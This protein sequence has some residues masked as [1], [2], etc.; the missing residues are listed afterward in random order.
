MWIFTEKHA[1]LVLSYTGED[2]AIQGML[3]G[4]CGFAIRCKSTTLVGAFREKAFHGVPYPRAGHTPRVTA[5]L[6][7]VC[8]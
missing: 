7:A 6:Q 5:L 3:A 8:T 2:R 4:S 1:M